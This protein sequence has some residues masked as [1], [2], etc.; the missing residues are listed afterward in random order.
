MGRGVAVSAAAVG[1]VGAAAACW[2]LYR[3]L[4]RRGVLD[5]RIEEV[6]DFW[7]GGRGGASIDALQRSLW[8]ARG[9]AR[10]A[11]DALV[12]KTFGVG[13]VAAAARGDLDA[14]TGTPRGAVA[15][16]VVLDQLSR[17]VGRGGDGALE[18][19]ASLRA[20]AV[21]EACFGAARGR[22][23][24]ARCLTPSQH[25]FALMC[26]RH[27]ADE[28]D[29]DGGLGAVLEVVEARAAS[30]A[31]EARALDRFR[32][33]TARRLRERRAP[34]TAAVA[35]AFG[36]FDEAAILER[37]VVPCDDGA[38]AWALG[39]SALGSTVTRFVLDECARRGYRA[40]VSDP[41][42]AS[43][44]FDRR[45]RA[46]PLCVVSLSGGVDSMVLCWVLAMLRDR[47]VVG[48]DGCFSMAACHVDYGNRAESGAEADF[49][50]AWCAK[51]EVDL[52]VLVMP[53]DLR[54]STC[55][56]ETYEAAAREKRFD[57]YRK[58]AK[59]QPVLLGHHV[60][61][62]GENCVSNV[63]KGCGVFDLSGMRDR[64]TLHGVTVA[65][66]LLDLAKDD[67][68][69]VSRRCGVPYFKDS[70]P[71]WSTRGRLRTEV[72][73]LLRDVYGAGSVG[74]V[75]KLARE[76]DA[77]RELADARAGK[78]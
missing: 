78:G 19:A 59:R 70:T 40:R 12:V 15:L 21:F 25:V 37:P 47:V 55:D 62:V 1:A 58:L 46:V 76:S 5:E 71:H 35:D 24:A 32:T 56:R 28:G 33:A 69:E 49:L 11:A 50:R 67:V 34:R 9:S 22:W 43:T 10:D 77:L 64:D 41:S 63:F 52:T 66:P 27:A 26:L 51:V 16:L 48:D 60:G 38:R 18:R 30:D 61:D 4:C 65:R 36:A 14:W 20:R 23:D 29:G 42:D 13:L 73:P 68:Y 74:H 54:R 8:F 17:H 53:A 75:E 31:L 2:Q 44:R 7:F 57:L 45:G 6:L 39:E 72:L 3:Q